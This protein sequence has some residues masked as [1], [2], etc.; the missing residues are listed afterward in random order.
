[1]AADKPVIG[2]KAS[3]D[4]C[5]RALMVLSDGAEKQFLEFVEQLEVWLT[6]RSQHKAELTRL[7]QEYMKSQAEVT[8]LEKLLKNAQHMFGLEREKR[9]ASQRQV[10]Q[11]HQMMESFKATSRKSGAAGFAGEESHE[12]LLSQLSLTLEQG[13][14]LGAL[15]ALD[16]RYSKAGLESP[17]GVLSTI[18]ENGDT[19]DAVSDIDLTEGDDLDTSSL[20]L[21]SGHSFNTDANAAPA[22]AR[23]RRSSGRKRAAAPSTD[24]DNGRKKRSK[25]TCDK[26]EGAGGLYPDLPPVY[27]PSAPPLQ[28][29][30]WTLAR[31]PAALKRHAPP[32]PANPQAV[33]PT[34]QYSTPPQGSPLL[35]SHLSASRVQRPHCFTTKMMYMSEY[36]QPCGKRIKFGKQVLKCRD[37]RAVCHLDCRSAVPL[38]CV[39]AAS[40][41]GS[42]Q[43]SGSIADYT[44]AVAPM[45]PAL[46]VHCTMEIERRGFTELGLYRVSVLE[47]DVKS[48]KEKFLRGKGFPCLTN[49][50]VH[51]MCN[52]VKDF[53]RCLKEPLITH[54]LWHQ[55]VAGANKREEADCEAALY[56]CISELPQ[57][58]RD[59]LA[60]MILHLQRVSEAKEC[61]MPVGNLAKVF[62]PTLVGYS[63]SDPEPQ[64]L[65]Q[66]TTDQ[67]N[68]MN[69]L[70]QI[71]SDYWDTF[72]NVNDE[73]M[74]SSNTN[75][76]D[77]GHLITPDNG[78][79][80]R[81]KSLLTRTPLTRGISAQ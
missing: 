10:Q 32:P 49:M 33:T 8:R 74:F 65:L 6:D 15:S 79:S 67:Q 12:Q 80:S 45:V 29:E 71:S 13:N 2:L 23:K 11:I 22:T 54:S 77:F 63:V 55:F 57:P 35:R 34:N 9:I 64:M 66:Q 70:L 27:P 1:M 18:D 52:A 75:I 31:T 53:L 4:D 36:C 60:W 59:T 56:Q 51:V 37:C 61:M 14:T 73:N 28:S 17:A 43:C 21:R 78:R 3:M 46:V 76:V 44:P 16:G 42:K 58:N 26:E 68:V 25:E 38:P 47:R 81:R 50:D 30:E 20:C 72:I 48:L 62:G 5:I 7:Q 24:D 41:P 69:K 19:L 40:T 39:P